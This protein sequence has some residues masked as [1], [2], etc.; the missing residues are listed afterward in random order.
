MYQRISLSSTVEKKLEGVRVFAIKLDLEPIKTNELNIVREWESLHKK[1][2]GKSK[3]VV[4]Q[5]ERIIA[6]QNFYKQLG[7]NPKKT[8]P[9]VQNIIQRFLIKEEL[10]R[11][12]VINPIVDGVNVAAVKHLIPLGVFDAACVEGEIKLT[13]S[14][15]GDWYRPLGSKERVELTPDTLVLTDDKKVL[16]QFCYRDS[17]E[18]K[19][20]DKTC[21][22]WLLGCQ[23]TSISADEVIKAMEDARLYLKQ[24]YNFKNTK[25]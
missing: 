8:P 22:I 16:S 7:L 14:Q 10:D 4:A 13:L 20:T 3:E 17:E 18:Q 21:S 5:T 1:W 9:S 19:I 25:L 11:I 6:Y 12:P 2:Q 15:S 24:I 23:V